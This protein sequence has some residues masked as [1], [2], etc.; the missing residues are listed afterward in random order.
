M[1]SEARRLCHAHRK[2][3]ALRHDI[4][5]WLDRSIQRKVIR[6]TPPNAVTVELVRQTRP[7]FD[8]GALKRG[9]WACC[10]E[11]RVVIRVTGEVT[12]DRAAEAL[13]EAVRGFAPFLR[14][15]EREFKG[16]KP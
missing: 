1:Q 3:A 10:E 13:H 6:K 5:E 8:A 2:C 16:E 7:L 15:V 14:E 9:A 12:S 4:G 11:S